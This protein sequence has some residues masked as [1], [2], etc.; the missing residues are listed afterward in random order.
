M[1][2]VFK[3]T[4][5]FIDIFEQILKRASEVKAIELCAGYVQS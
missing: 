4:I 3:V 1:L 2:N 5:I